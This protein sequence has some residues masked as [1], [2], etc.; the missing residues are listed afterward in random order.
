MS[1]PVDR[2]RLRVPVK[3]TRYEL[4]YIDYYYSTQNISSPSDS[5]R[6]CFY[7]QGFFDGWFISQQ[8]YSISH[9][10]SQSKFNITTLHSTQHAHTHSPS[11]M[12]T[13]WTSMQKTNT[14]FR[15]LSGSGFIRIFG[16]VTRQA[17]R[18]QS[19]SADISSLSTSAR[20]CS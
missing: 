6:L 2:R 8:E 4:L 14:C 5:D 3:R 9:R 13:R 10:Q 18:S 19:L 20:M 12:S 16:I 15:R 11:V 7:T 1:L 17:L